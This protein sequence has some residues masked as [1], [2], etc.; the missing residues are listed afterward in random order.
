MMIEKKMYRFVL[1]IFIS[2]SLATEMN[3][4]ACKGTSQYDRCSTNTACGCFHRINTNESSICGFLW[5]SCSQLEPCRPSDNT[6]ARKD[7]IC[8]QHRRCRNH[9][10]CYPLSMMN[11]QI[12]PSITTT[13]ISTPVREPKWSFTKNLIVTRF[14]NTASVLSDGK[15]LVVGGYGR[16]G[17]ECFNTAEL[18]DH[19]TGNWTLTAS[20]SIERV[21]HTASVLA[22]GKVLVVGGL[23]C[24]KHGCLQSAELYDPRTDTW[25]STG[26]LNYPRCHHV[27]TVLKNGKVLVVGGNPEKKLL[28]EPDA[29]ISKTC[30]LYDPITGMWTLTGGM[31]NGRAFEH[32]VS[33]LQD[34][35]VLVTGDSTTIDFKQVAELYD[36][37]TESWTVTG[38]TNYNR[39]LH[40]ATVLNNGKVL[41]AGGATRDQSTAELYDPKTGNWTL[42]GSMNDGRGA[43]GALLLTNGKVLVV[44]GDNRTSTGIESAELYDPVTE[45]WSQTASMQLGRV[46]AQT[47][48]LFDGSVLVTSGP[49]LEYLNVGTAEIYSY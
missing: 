48:M 8:V 43:H 49:N 10:V 14:E 23:N 11:Q 32:Q 16:Y 40:T 22:D 36:P 24:R 47:S 42:T 45:S 44:G 18:Y 17:Y 31:H 34:G 35:K 41:V 29:N 12:C 4:E 26:S 27:A 21:S 30:E 28:H 25:T 46:L 13:T 39:Q 5:A 1:I 6:C 33:L 37:L 3:Y 9:P 38:K 20:S 7:S 2:A 15:V 19:T